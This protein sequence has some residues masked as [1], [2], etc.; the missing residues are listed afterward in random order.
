[1]N[2]SFILYAIAMAM[3]VAAVVMSFLSV[4]GT[5]DAGPLLG[6]GLFC[7]ALAGLNASDK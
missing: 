4:P 5:F 1:M 3:G 6:I 2:T 7:A